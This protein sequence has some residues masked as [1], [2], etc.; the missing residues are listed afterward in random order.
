ME[1]EKDTS[2]YH[3]LASEYSKVCLFF[4]N[5]AKLFEENADNKRMISIYL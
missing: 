2:K 1:A 5:Y 4:N 3:K